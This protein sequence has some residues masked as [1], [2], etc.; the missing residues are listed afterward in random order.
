MKK[1]I[2]SS[3]GNEITYKNLGLTLIAPDYEVVGHM[4]DVCKK[5]W[6]FL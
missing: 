2:L 5:F 4:I 6:T 3:M 1:M